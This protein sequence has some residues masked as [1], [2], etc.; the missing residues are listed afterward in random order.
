MLSKWQGKDITSST[1]ENYVKTIIRNG[2]ISINFVTTMPPN[3]RNEW[4]E[5]QINLAR[6]RKVEVRCFGG[7]GG[8]LMG[9]ASI[10]PLQNSRRF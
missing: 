4:K 6:R 5:S 9:E 1:F 7:R 8:V 3:Y 10:L 2:T